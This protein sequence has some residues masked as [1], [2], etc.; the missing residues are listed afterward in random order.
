VL[1]CSFWIGTAWPEGALAAMMAAVAC[2][3]GASVDDPAT[4][5]LNFL[6]GTAVGIVIAGV[7]LFAILPAVSGFAMMALVL[8]PLYITLSS[9]GAIPAYFPM[10][11]PVL[12]GVTTML[13][14][15][16]RMSFDFLSFANSA[17][18]QI[19]AMAAAAAALRVARASGAEFAIRR[20]IALIHRDLARLARGDRALTRA[21]FESRMLDRVDGLLQRRAGGGEALERMIDGALAALRFGLNLRLLREQADALPKGAGRVLNRVFAAVVLHFAPGNLDREKSFGL[22]DAAL[23][24]ALAAAS[25]IQ[26]ER[27]SAILIVLGQLQHIM[28]LHEEFFVA[29]PARNQSL[30]RF[31]SDMEFWKRTSEAAS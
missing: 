18:A 13:G 6:I 25:E 16:N 14:I 19:I 4:F 20:I 26:T 22:L 3:L 28:A 2:S 23:T 31:W 30:T 11:L 12:L 9:F 8:A 21:R 10:A 15:E 1:I 5:V 17:I 27:A 24:E 7:Y 29:A